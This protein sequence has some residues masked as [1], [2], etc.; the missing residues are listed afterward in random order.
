MQ[1]QPIT[2]DGKTL[3]QWDQEVVNALDDRDVWRLL[4]YTLDD[5]I[6]E[7]TFESELER[8]LVSGLQVRLIRQD[9]D[10]IHHH[11]EGAS[12]ISSTPF[13]DNAFVNVTSKLRQ[14]LHDASIPHSVAELYVVAEIGRFLSSYRDSDDDEGLREHFT[15]NAHPHPHNDTSTDGYGNTQKCTEKTKP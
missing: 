6:A 15:G 9:A 1:H 3:D 7:Y 12:S 5:Y 13:W 2:I 11:H 8:Q 4:D 14:I 10:L